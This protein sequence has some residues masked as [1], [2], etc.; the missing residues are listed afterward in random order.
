[1][2][3]ESI[4]DKLSRVRKPHVHISYKVETGDAE[5][6]KELPFVLGIMGDYAGDTKLK[7]LS[8]EEDFPGYTLRIESGLDMSD[9]LTL[10]DV[11]LSGFKFEAIEGGSVGITFSATVHGDADDFGAICQQIQNVVDVSLEPPRA[12]SQ[13]QAQRDIEDEAEETAEA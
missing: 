9:P 6:V 13:R 5:E 2:A 10:N 12:E 3:K 11:E 4:H 7:P 1:M 8:L